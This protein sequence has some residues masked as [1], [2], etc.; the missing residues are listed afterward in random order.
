M[1]TFSCDFRESKEFLNLLLDNINIAVL[2]ADEN[3]RIQH[4]NSTFLQLFGKPKEDV[5]ARGFGRATDC[6]YRVEENKECGNTSHCDDCPV[7]RSISKT[8]LEEI[9]VDK[10]RMERVF[11]VLGRPVT[12]HLEITTRPLSFQGQKM[13]LIILYD[14][15]EMEEQ[16]GQLQERQ[17]QI[18]LDLEAAAGIQRS[19]LPEST[20]QNDALDIA[21][22]FEPC[23]RVGGDSFNIV[24][25]DEERVDFCMLDVCGHGVAAAFIAVSVSQFLQSRRR[26]F[27][28]DPDAALPSAV[29]TSLDGAFP[30]ER[31]NTY[32]TMIYIS[33]D[34]REGVLAYSSAGH[35]P[36][37]LLRQTGTIEILDRRGPSIGLGTGE[38]F[39]QEEK[40]LRRGDKIVVYTDGIPE[41]HDPAG[42]IFGTS[43]FHDIL[44]RYHS[45]SPQKL[46][47]AVY[48]AS[49]EF[50]GTA[51]LEDDIT[52]L[53]A[54]YLGS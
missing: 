16:K 39:L 1:E 41:I 22:K 46:A 7:R 13:T 35:P 20:S 30:F 12:K 45:E 23:R 40:V 3:L 43:R 42:E 27:G 17:S 38:P 34:L 15:T 9:P 29:L 53:I 4:V 47:E 6:K 28:K 8:M 51:E 54:E 5:L 25:R 21:W 14:V 26:F 33:I 18:D 44:R 52:L 19:L 10:A 24:Y 50:G 32:F 36:P 31:F 49:R 37:V 2:I 11:Y 48:A